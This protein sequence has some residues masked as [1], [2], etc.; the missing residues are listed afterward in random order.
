MKIRTNLLL[1]LLAFVIAFGTVFAPEP[2]EAKILEVNE[3][4]F[5]EMSSD[6]ESGKS[7]TV[8]SLRNH[9]AAAVTWIMS[10]HLRGNEL[11]YKIWLSRII[12]SVTQEG[13]S[14]EYAKYDPFHS[15]GPIA[16]LT[17]EKNSDVDIIQL[18]DECRLSCAEKLLL[19]ENP[20]QDMWD[21]MFARLQAE[22]PLIGLEEIIVKAIENGITRNVKEGYERALTKMTA[23]YNGLLEMVKIGVFLYHKNIRIHDNAGPNFI[24]TP[25]HRNELAIN[26]IALLI[27]ESLAQVEMRP[28]K[29]ITDVF[30]RELF[31]AGF[32]DVV[33]ALNL[34]AREKQV[35][36]KNVIGVEIRPF[37]I[38]TPRVREFLTTPSN[39]V[40]FNE[41]DFN[42][43]CRLDC[44]RAI[45]NEKVVTMADVSVWKSVFGLYICLY[46]QTTSEEPINS[47]YLDIFAEVIFQEVRKWTT[48]SMKIAFHEVG[49]EQRNIAGLAY[50]RLYSKL[51]EE[52]IDL[53]EEMKISGRERVSRGIVIAMR[54]LSKE[55]AEMGVA[56]VIGSRLVNREEERVLVE[57]AEEGRTHGE[58]SRARELLAKIRREGFVKTMKDALARAKKR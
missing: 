13:K 1:I 37:D 46:Q 48:K 16:Q 30:V 21:T 42:F 44:V 36:R 6:I 41:F 51:G 55:S 52:G 20:A 7:K 56:R 10:N 12:M 23:P 25:N 53:G 17:L 32:E 3:M 14:G 34:T 19:S 35:F 39:V 31:A 15:L 29:P 57:T 27:E 4:L 9:F 18:A 47:K 28:E 26:Y 8:T 2:D 50:A 58:R 22:I 33:R 49:S 45:A 40:D 54:V 11:E 5:K 24:E 43:G 38:L